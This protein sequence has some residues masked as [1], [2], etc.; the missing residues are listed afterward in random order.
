MALGQFYFSQKEM[1]EAEAQM[2]EPADLEAKAAPPRLL[3]A[4]IYVTTGKLS[5]GERLYARL[6]TLA[7]WDPVA[8]RAL[9]LFYQSTRQNEKAVTE[10]QSVIAAKPGDLVAKADLIDTLI[11][12]NR[13]KEAEAL[14]AGVLQS[15]PGD[16]HALLSSG[17]MLLAQARYQEA[18][19]TLQSAIKSA[20]ESGIAHYFL[21]VAQQF[22]G[23]SDLARSSFSDALKL[24]PEMTEAAVA[25]AGIDNKRGDYDEALRI[26][27]DALK[28][29]SNLS[30][31]Y[32]ASAQAQL[33]K[34]DLRQ[35][36]ALLQ[37]A[38]QRDPANLPA[39]ALMLALRG[40]QGRSEEDVQDLSML[41]AQHP[42]E[43]GLHLLLAVGYL[44]L[45]D[46]DKSEAS[47]RQALALDPKIPNAYTLLGNIDF[48][49]GEIEKGKADFRVAI[50]LN[51]HNLSNYAGLGSEFEK[52]ANGRMPRNSLKRLMAWNPTL[53]SSR[54]NWP[55]STLSTAGMSTLRSTLPRPPN[56]CCRTL[57]L[58]PT[59][60]AGPI[61][62]LD[63]LSQLSNN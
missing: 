60:L 46:L 13:I 22:L 33:A 34:G 7:P 15:S 32:T 30:L 47:A 39:L 28:T 12:L 25:L 41:I 49:R 62:R 11:D 1:A 44:N 51:P 23:F 40:K 9:G 57:R 45:K 10:L 59:P 24:S 4:R 21:G 3:L 35:G 52:R 63:P 14:N 8:F 26:A 37:E 16:A 27:G 18:A 54:M 56:R 50:E 55:I 61:T 43:A 58:R 5:E 36:E 29:N 20:P 2:R 19:A 31:A 53:L 48:A 6:K 17:R 38:L 42:T